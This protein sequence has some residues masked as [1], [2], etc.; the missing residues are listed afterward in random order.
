VKIRRLAAASLSLSLLLLGCASGPGGP[1]I[2]RSQWHRPPTSS[3]EV[4]AGLGT[5]LERGDRRSVTVGMLH[6]FQMGATLSEASQAR[7]A[8][9]LDPSAVPWDWREPPL[10]A[11]RFAHNFR[12]NARKEGLSAPLASVPAEH[13]LI[14]GIAWDQAT[15]RLFAGSVI[16]RRLLVREGVDRHLLVSEG[17]D[18][19]EVPTAA[20]IGGVFGT[21]VDAPRRLLWLASSAA[22]PMPRPESAFSGLVA[23]DLETL[24][25]SRRIAVPGARLGDVAVAP[26]GTVFASDGRSG[27]IYRCRPG[28]AEAETLIPP[29]LL[30]SPQGMVAWPGGRLLYVADYAMGLFRIDLGSRRIRPVFAHLPL[31][32]D[33]IDGLVRNGRRLLA[34]QNGTRPVRIVAISLDNG[35]RRVSDLR[36]LEQGGEGWGEPTLGTMIGD[37]LAYIADGQWERY[38]P[39]GALTDGGAPR[40]TAIRLVDDDSDHILVD[41]AKMPGRGAL[42]SLATPRPGS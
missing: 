12:Y 39:G 2:V 8:P 16:D 31:M 17:E 35:A 33:G 42:L 23:I 24:R 37:S 3:S 22:D 38:G 26:D 25:E 18:W 20:P 14:E 6:L 19:R 34:I 29:G 4:R 28:C 13:R 11:E 7:L 41:A 30:K 1:R 9:L 32:L 27:A 5:A 15:R 21:A 10:L 36:V 40:P